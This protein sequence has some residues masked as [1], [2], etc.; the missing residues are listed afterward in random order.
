[1][2]KRLSAACAG[3]LLLA[4]ADPGVGRS[5]S[6]DAAYASARR[7]HLAG[8]QAQAAIAYRAALAADPSHVNARN[9]LATLYAEQGDYAHAIPIWLA[10]TDKLTLG[11][12]PGAA[13]LFSNLGYAYLLDG[14]YDKAVTALEK[15]CLLDPLRHRAWL[16]LGHALYKLGQEDR[17]RQMFSQ[18]NALQEHDFRSDYAVSG[19]S[20]VHAIADAVKAA[21]REEQEWAAA[22]VVVGEAGMLELRR[23]DTA[24]AKAHHEIPSPQPQSPVALPEVVLLEIR[25]GNGVTGMARAL[26]RRIGDPAFKVVRLSNEKGFHVQQTRIEYQAKFQAAAER[27]AQH[28]GATQMLRMDAIGPAELRLVIGHDLTRGKLALHPMLAPE[29]KL[30]DASEGDKSG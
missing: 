2:I 29:P 19:G 14:Q 20:D 13:Y 23:V 7:Y 16:H 21:P 26:S 12:G 8:Q 28:V 25:N 24:P 9:G 22:D 17:A 11:S 5:Q 18:A 30:A 15:A 1:M 10:L 27:L 4:C 6:A 3:A